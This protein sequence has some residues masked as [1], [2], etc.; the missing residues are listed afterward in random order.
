MTRGF[1]WC[2]TLNNPDEDDLS[3][4][5][6]F[7]AKNL[8]VG[9]EVGESGTPHFQWAI[10]GTEQ[11]YSIQTM[12]NAL[13][14]RAHCEYARGT[15]EDQVNYCSKDGDVRLHWETEPHTGQGRRSDIEAVREAAAEGQTL[16]QILLAHPAACRHVSNTRALMEALAPVPEMEIFQEQ[17]KDPWDWVNGETLYVYGPTGVGK[18]EWAKQQLPKALFVSQMDQLR[19]YNPA[20]YD[21]II[22][23]DVDLSKLG[24]SALIHL[25]DST[26]GRFV[27]C[28]Y[29]N[30]FIPAHT[31]KIF[32]FNENQTENW[33]EAAKRRTTV[34]HWDEL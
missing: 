24:D 16:K 27:M 6:D 2:G 30:G 3:Y 21:G 15:W 33:S 1:N 5:K 31:K 28:R 22:F 12:R 10:Y 19:Q 4:F 9:H 25:T 7:P 32:T 18:T 13:G 11:S 17:R 14:G 26:M 29:Y 23:D 20:D 8:I 34:R